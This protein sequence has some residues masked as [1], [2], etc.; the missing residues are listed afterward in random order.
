MNENEKTKNR[1]IK[2]TT[3]LLN[4]YNGETKKITSRC[5]AQRAG[6]GLGTINYFFGSKENLIA[7]CVQRSINQM[8]KGFTPD[9]KDYSKTDG[10]T[11]EAR[12]ISWAAQTFDFLFENQVISSISILNDLQ[13]YSADS[14]C[15][16]TQKGFSFA[17]RG[18]QKE[19]TK[20]LL[21]FIL[22]SAMQT[23]FLAKSMAKELFGY[24]LYCKTERDAFI[25]DTVTMLFHGTPQE[26]AANER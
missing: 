4:E 23:A 22:V 8:L 19:E 14:N 12:L 18:P 1:I 21:V 24:D 15:V 10:L 7:E 17:V 11:D 13:N 20:T 16:Y 25:N 3:E 5:I 2:I 6:I 26:D 9:I